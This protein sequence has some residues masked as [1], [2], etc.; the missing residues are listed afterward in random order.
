MTRIL[1]LKRVPENSARFLISSLFFFLLF[2]IFFPPNSF[3]YVRPLEARENGR[4][5]QFD[6]KAGD[7]LIVDKFQQITRPGVTGKDASR[8]EKNRIVLKG[9]RVIEDKT[10][11]EGSFYTY[12][13]E[14]AGKGD[15]RQDETYSSRFQ[16][17]PRGAYLVGDSFYM[18]NLRSLP[19]FP[20]RALK[21]GERWRAPAAEV[22]ILEGVKISVPIDVS[23][24]YKGMEIP[25]IEGVARKKMHH[26]TYTYKYDHYVRNRKSRVIRIQCVSMDE[27]FFDGE[28][29]IPAY[30]RDRL[31]YTFTL[32]DGSPLHFAYNIRSFYK[33]ERRS[34]EEQ[35]KRVEEEVARQMEKHG[36]VKVRRDK[37]GVILDF[38]DI[39]F[40]TDSSTLSPEAKSVIIDVARTLAAQPGYEIRIMGHT[41]SRGTVEHNQ[42]LSESRARSVLEALKKEP[43]MDPARFSFK[44]YGESKP[45][46]TNETPEGRA[47]NRRVEILI[48]ME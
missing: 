38:P 36:D 20:D 37:N 8:D 7:L 26:I 27:L 47:K 22:M 32:S 2:Q 39:L 30:D 21:P 15:Y 3:F 14:P 25:E 9:D 48:L 28:N 42:K 4:W 24:E 46:A 18:P 13:R 5:N 31:M 34:T 12:S 44:G 1:F 6:L 19:T 35:K 23:Y 41:D 40:H 10:E 45:V 43:A 29:G 16:I 11:L 17:N 33:K